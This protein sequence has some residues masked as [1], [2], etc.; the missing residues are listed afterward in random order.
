MIA[1]SDWYHI[2]SEAFVC[3]VQALLRLSFGAQN[4][5]AWSEYFIM[6][7]EASVIC[8]RIFVYVLLFY[9]GCNPSIPMAPLNPTSGTTVPT[10]MT[11]SFH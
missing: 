10:S 3:S 11:Q 7:E 9:A 4:R 5:N 2:C 1:W 8:S 6:T